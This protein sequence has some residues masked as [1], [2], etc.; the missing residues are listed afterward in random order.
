MAS[1]PISDWVAFARS[2]GGSPEYQLKPLVI[3]AMS[4]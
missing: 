1:Y 4:K 3:A 2:E